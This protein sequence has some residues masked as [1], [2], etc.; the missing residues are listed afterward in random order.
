VVFTCPTTEKLLSPL[1]LP[2]TF[3]FNPDAPAAVDMLEA[4]E[5]AS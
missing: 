5:G 2:S 1:K 3:L 4:T